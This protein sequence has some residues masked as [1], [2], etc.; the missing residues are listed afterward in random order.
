MTKVKLNDSVDGVQREV[1]AFSNVSCYKIPKKQ[2]LQVLSTV[3]ISGLRLKDFLR[4]FIFV[5]SS[6]K[7]D[8]K[9]VLEKRFDEEK[10]KKAFWDSEND[11]IT[12]ETGTN[13]YVVDTGNDNCDFVVDILNVFKI[14]LIEVKNVNVKCYKLEKDVVACPERTRPKRTFYRYII[15]DADVQ[16]K[17]LKE[18]SHIAKRKTI[19]NPRL[20]KHLSSSLI[21]ACVQLK[22][23]EKT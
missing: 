8:M 5:W 22:N 14:A 17:I 3:N 7:N 9:W 2:K 18:T 15:D 16:A 20:F 12:L 13:L 23:V 1:D 10:S 19:E 4:S 21:F 6:L 11:Q